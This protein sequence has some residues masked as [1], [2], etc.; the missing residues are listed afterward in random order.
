VR[1]TRQVARR[2]LRRVDYEEGLRSDGSSRA[3]GGSRRRA[4]KGA[5][6]AGRQSPDRRLCFFLPR[7]FRQRRGRRGSVPPVVERL[8]RISGPRGPSDPDRPEKRRR[9]AAESSEPGPG[10]APRT[11]RPDP[12]EAFPIATRQ[13]LTPR[14]QRQCE[15]WN[16]PKAEARRR[17]RRWR[18]I[19]S[20]QIVSACPA[21]A[22]V[23]AS[24]QGGRV[25]A[26]AG[27]RSGAGASHDDPERIL[28]LTPT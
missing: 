14:A 11:G 10:A 27:P 21:P 16:G 18:G 6:R 3:N 5:G 26:R 8:R 22:F 12:Q 1:S 15:A 23:P 25:T 13:R 24:V 9:R 7:T 2:R 28:R 19:C 20:R 4:G 17:G